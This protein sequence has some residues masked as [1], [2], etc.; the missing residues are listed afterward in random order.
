MW[1]PASSSPKLSERLGQ[2]VVIDNRGGANRIIGTE[3]A[4]KS[5][6]DGYTI[7][8]GATALA[9]NPSLYKL[10]FDVAKDFAPITQTVESHF[11]AVVQQSSPATTIAGL[12]ALAISRPGQISYGSPGEG[13]VAH[14]AGELLKNLTG[15]KLVHVPYKGSPQALTDLMGGQ[16]ELTFDVIATSLPL[17]KAGKLR[18]LAVTGAKRST[19]LPDMPTV[20]ETVPGFNLVGWQGI[21]AP[22]G[23]RARSS[24]SSIAKSSQSSICRISTSV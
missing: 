9:N 23:R 8:L 17:V 24:G 15:I 12:I 10:P 20:A 11:L 21:F 16:I 5:P 14:L 4:A 18:A 19:I 6:A 13:S 2:S 7:L 22:A 1:S 3:M